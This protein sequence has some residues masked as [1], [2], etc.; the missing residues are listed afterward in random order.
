M[1]VWLRLKKKSSLELAAL[2]ISVSACTMINPQ[3]IDTRE[4]KSSEQDERNDRMKEP[5]L[6]GPVKRTSDERRWLKH[7]QDCPFGEW[8]YISQIPS[9]TFELGIS[10]QVTQGRLSGMGRAYSSYR[11]IPR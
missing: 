10:W 6:L 8:L 7:Q 1:L 2:L 5:Y 3:G 4:L 9:N 11:C